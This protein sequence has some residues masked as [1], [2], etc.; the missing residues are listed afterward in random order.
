[1]EKVGSHKPID[2]KSVEPANGYMVVLSDGIVGSASV[3]TIMAGDSSQYGE[4]Q[5]VLFDANK[6]HT[7]DME[8][9]TYHLVYEGSI[10]GI[11]NED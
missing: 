2:V 7:F 8:G 3:G 5:K 9:L 10:L 4:D 11:V 6:A 1:M